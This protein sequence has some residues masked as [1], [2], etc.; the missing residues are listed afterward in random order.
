MRVAILQTGFLGD[1]V[2][3]SPLVAALKAHDPQAFITLVV[4]SSKSC[5]AALIPGVDSVLSFDKRGADR[6]PVGLL[7]TGARLS[8]AAFD[9][10]LA[11]H[12]SSRTTL[13]AALSRAPRRIG[14]TKGL[15]RALFS[16]PVPV[17]FAE[18][19]R[20]EQDFDLLRAVGIE[21]VS[22][23]P[24]LRP[25]PEDYA[26]SFLR[27][28]GSPAGA[29]VGICV[30]TH[31]PTKAWPPAKV[32]KLCHLLSRHDLV[33]IL[34]G[35]PADREAEHQVQ[36]EYAASLVSQ[37]L[38]A[39]RTIATS[40]GNT[41]PEAISLLSRCDLVI[42]P[43]TGLVHAAKAVAGATIILYGPTDHR[44]H[45]DLESTTKVHL[46]LACQPC[47]RHGPRRC[48][49]GHHGCMQGIEPEEIARLALAKL[50][51]SSTRKGLE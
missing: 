27:S 29:L 44:L 38:P 36:A 28:L 10:V 23:R 45:H 4:T 20:L 11:P 43:D 32:A 9:L 15:G 18:P 42:G 8:D 39:G 12:R 6:G 7:R 17:R 19:C 35:G 3:S 47:H 21:P 30:G 24:A 46:D 48:P 41:I 40:V 34:F 1:V 25:G 51:L 31:W 16:D 5:L 22:V 49:E 50:E 37:G 2:L 14:F 13:L 26:A 33:P